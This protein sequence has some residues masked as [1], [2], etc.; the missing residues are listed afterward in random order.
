MSGLIR[1]LNLRLKSSGLSIAKKI[2]EDQND[3]NITAYNED[4]GAVFRI[5]LSI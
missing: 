1:A 3:A 4:D 2:I 5:T